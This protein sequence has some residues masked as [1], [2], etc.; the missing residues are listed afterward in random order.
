MAFFLSE[1]YSAIRCTIHMISNISG[2][3]IQSIPDHVALPMPRPR[4]RVAARIALGAIRNG[5]IA[6][7]MMPAQYHLMPRFS[8]P[9]LG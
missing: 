9:Q 1:A 6:Q 4:S 2:T 7:A 8:R 3:V 5:R